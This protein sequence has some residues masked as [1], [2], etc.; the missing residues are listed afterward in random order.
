METAELLHY[1][2]RLLESDSLII[3]VSQSGQSA[4]IV[5]LAD[6]VRGRAPL[7]A[8][9]NTSASPLA[10]SADVVLH[11]H[12][13]PEAT[14]ACKTYVCSL[15]VLEWLGALL[16]GQDAA[17]VREELSHA[18]PAVERY[19][20]H[21]REH[22]ASL[23]EQLV[24]VRRIFITGRGRSLA[25]AENGGLILKEAMRFHA[26]G[27]SCPAFRHGPFE[28]LRDEVL[29]IVMAGDSRTA[30]QN[31]RLADDITRAGGRAAVVDSQDAAP[32][33]LIPESSERVRPILEILPV[34]MITLALGVIGGRQPGS[35]ALN[36]KVTTTE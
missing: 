22:V 35:F 28:V 25:A 36:T 6:A 16:T 12:A 29:V 5:A 10:S 7:I 1:Q 34:Q 9:T 30:S 19:L 2:Q 33:F 21:W 27:M 24:P 23:A 15:L 14:V 26:E 32:R 3:V 13:G 17:T 8:L 20:A 18:A 11:M 4:E 31:R